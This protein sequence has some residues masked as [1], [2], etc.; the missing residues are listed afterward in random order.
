MSAGGRART[1]S[2][3]S[4]PPSATPSTSPSRTAATPASRQSSP[5]SSWASLSFPSS[6]SSSNLTRP[7]R[8][9][10]SHFL[11]TFHPHLPS[12]YPHPLPAPSTQTVYSHPRPRHDPRHNAPAQEALLQSG[13]GCRDCGLHRRVRAAPPHRPRPPGLLALPSQHRASFPLRL[14]AAPSLLRVL[15]SLLREGCAAGR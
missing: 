6:C 3:S 13:G 8:S 14:P 1:A 5:R 4:G 2:A 7:W 11:P 10:C 9:A 15:F 12:P